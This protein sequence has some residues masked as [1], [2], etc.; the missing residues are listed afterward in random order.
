MDIMK[1]CK[2][3]IKPLKLYIVL[4]A[5]CL[6][7]AEVLSGPPDYYFKRY[8]YRKKQKS[9]RQYTTQWMI[10]TYVFKYVVFAGIILKTLVKY[11][12]RRDG[13]F[14]QNISNRLVFTFLS[15]NNATTK[16]IYGKP[17]NNNSV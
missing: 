3:F 17:N 2:I 6:L 5:F 14:H 1:D 4:V 10:Y 11:P 13:P 9:V 16:N 12:V 15:V 8:S 7:L